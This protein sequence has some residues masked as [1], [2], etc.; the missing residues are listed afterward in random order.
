ML[1]ATPNDWNTLPRDDTLIPQ[2]FFSHEGDNG[3]ACEMLRELLHRLGGNK[4]GLIIPYF[5]G[6]GEPTLPEI[7]LWA[8]CHSVGILGWRFKKHFRI[9]VAACLTPNVRSIL[10]TDL[11]PC[12]RPLPTVRCGQYCVVPIWHPS[13]RDNV[14]MCIPHFVEL[15]ED[16][17]FEVL[18]RLL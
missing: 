15:Y 18:Q 8:L 14:T 9:H 1:P 5:R 16:N 11:F 17:V 13:L 7:P 6:P 2:V 4:R 3:P 12:V 10:T